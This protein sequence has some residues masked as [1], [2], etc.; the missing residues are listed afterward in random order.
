MNTGTC[1]VKRTI[2]TGAGFTKNFGG[3]LAHEINDKVLSDPNIVRCKK[4]HDLIQNEFNYEDALSVVKQPDYTKEE[5]QFLRQAVKHVYSRQDVEVTN[6]NADSQNVG[7]FKS[8]AILTNFIMRAF[9]F[10]GSQDSAYMF[11]TNQ[12][13]FVEA[14]IRIDHK[15]QFRPISVPGISS[16][17][18]GIP[19]GYHPRSGFNRIQVEDTTSNVNA[20]DFRQK[21]NYIKLHGSANWDTHDGDL[22]VIGRS[23]EDDI[24]A[25]PL[26]KTY[27]EKFSSVCNLQDMRML[28]VGYGFCDGHIN[29]RIA[30][31]IKN[32]LKLWVWDVMSRQDWMRK[33][34][35][36]DVQN[37]IEILGAVEGYMS[38]DFSRIFYGNSISKFDFDLTLDRFLNPE[39]F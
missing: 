22:L 39:H 2:L 10:E 4:L 34:R 23:K 36:S 1:P 32:G 17:D 11:T 14:C 19:A 29:R 9:R 30:D 12:D 26:L 38:D 24:A 33:M 7:K 3:Y 18:W 35:S 16:G 5:V 20:I 25:S 8:P 6:W 37:G 27:H 28:A 21:V 13:V 31:G 15:H